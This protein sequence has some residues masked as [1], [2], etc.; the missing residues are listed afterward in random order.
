MTKQTITINHLPL[1]SRAVANL[2][3]EDEARK[4][5]EFYYARKREDERR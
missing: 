3:R 5:M 2:T 4:A 1:V